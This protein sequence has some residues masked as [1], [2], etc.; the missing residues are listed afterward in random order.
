MVV[1]TTIGR[2]GGMP[3]GDERRRAI[4]LVGRRRIELGW[5]RMG[6]DRMKMIGAAFFHYLFFNRRELRR[7][8]RDCTLNAV[9]FSLY[10]IPP[11][12]GALTGLHSGRVRF[13]SVL[14]R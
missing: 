9:T 4:R 7:N 13:Y 2:G 10:F 12:R 1:T 8:L 14:S 11:I 5:V 3:A 6:D